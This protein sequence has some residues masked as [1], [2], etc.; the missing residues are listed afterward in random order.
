MFINLEETLFLIAMVSIDLDTLVDAQM[1][2]PL[3]LS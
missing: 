2:A 1:T 3:F